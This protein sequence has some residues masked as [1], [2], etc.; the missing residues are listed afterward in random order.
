MR[1]ITQQWGNY[2]TQIVELKGGINENV[3][4]L[5]LQAG[6]LIDVKNYMIAEG[7]YGGYVSMKG[8]ERFDGTSLPSLYESY[9]FT[10]ENCTN[11]VA[12]TDVLTGDSSGATA[13]A[14]VDGTLIS[15]TYLA[16][17]AV[18]SVQAKILTGSYIGEEG[19]SVGA[20]PIGSIQLLQTLIGGTDDY[21]EGI[22][23]KRANMI[24]VPGEGRL[25]GVH[26]WQFKVYAWR[27]KVGLA[28]IGMYIE[29]PI[30]GWAEIDTSAD[31]LVYDASTGHNFKFFDYNFTGDVA[32]SA[33]YWV[34]GTNQAREYKATGVTTVNNAGLGAL[35]KPIDIKV[36]NMYLFLAYRGGSLQHSVLGDPLDW[37][38][39]SGAGELTMGAEITNLIPGV[40]GTMV[41]FLARGIRILNGVVASEFSLE[42]FSDQSGAYTKTAQ[43]LLGTVFFV[44]DRGLSTLE[45]SDTFGDYSA[46]SISQ[47]F[48]TTLQRRL[49]EIN[50]TST[51][52]DL[53]QYR[54]FFSDRTG[55]IVSFEGK[56]FQGATFFEYPIEVSIIDQ[57][58]GANGYDFIVFGA[59]DESGYVYKLDSGYSFD[60]TPITCRLTT[61]F[62]HYGSPRNW[63]VFK[64]ATLEIAGTTD[65]MFDI[66]VDFDYN[67]PGTGRSIWKSMQVYT[68]DGSAIYGESKWGL[69]KYGTAT[70][71]TNRVPVYIVGLGVNMSYKVISNEAYRPQHIIQNII[72]DYELN[73][74]RQ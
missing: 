40:K 71:V 2:K 6:E 57:R 42:T 50:V 60:G 55:I 68:V 15:G 66:K 65:Q 45:A 39:A 33:F 36:H 24:P 67:E 59:N 53:N 64:R 29:D 22:D 70:S 48:K 30:A 25:L 21:H 69:M 28:E 51:S 34:D 31:P 27:K 41:I 43:R 7:G 47:R 35:D 44:D 46:N 56:E 17:D 12:A 16:G 8:F 20:T 9:V 73:S 63:K 49:K 14:F 61:A 13:E 74:R 26:I 72:T 18:V 10:L 3:S 37:T 19:I 54:I 4:S 52:R 5:E 38:G 32:D 1:P 58:R 23:W 62:F 11:A